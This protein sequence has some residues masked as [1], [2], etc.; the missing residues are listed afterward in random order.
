[1]QFTTGYEE[2]IFNEAAYFVAVRGKGANRI[3]TEC[4]SFNEAKACGSNHSDKR[5]MIYAVNELGS[6]AHICNV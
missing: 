4:T 1:M 6:A 2:K 5:T 3:R